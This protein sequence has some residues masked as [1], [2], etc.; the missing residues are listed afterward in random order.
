MSQSPSPFP[1]RSSLHSALALA[2]SFAAFIF[3]IHFLSSLWG[4]HLGYGFFRD[5]LYFLVCGRH[6]AWG[7]VDQPPL[8]AL[9]ARLAETA[10]RHLAHRHSHLQLSGR[11]ASP[12]ASPACSPGNSADAAPRRCWP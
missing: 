2:S 11:A 5:E 1:A 7:Y 12:S 9:Q 10:L 8:V 3:L 6:L 4:I